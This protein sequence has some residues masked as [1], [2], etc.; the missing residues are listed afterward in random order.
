MFDFNSLHEHQRRSSVL[1]SIQYVSDD[2]RKALG[3]ALTPLSLPRNYMLLDATKVAECAYFLTQGFAIAYTF[4]KG[5]KHVEWFWGPGQIL[6]SARSFFEQRPSQEFIQL[7][8]DS[9]LY[10][11]THAEVQ[12]LFD[13]YPE[14]HS[15]YR[16][17]MNH[18]YELSRER[19]RDMQN[20]T[21]LERYEKLIRTLPGIEQYVSQGEIASYLGIEPQSFSRM[22]R[23]N[24]TR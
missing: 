13:K 18:Y 16:V 23:R 7:R 4:V 10:C 17:I 12:Q 5:R 22:K 6:M 8:A 3:E 15:V 1:S 19:T 14:A 24:R 20:L 11:I 21:A 9:D 2:L